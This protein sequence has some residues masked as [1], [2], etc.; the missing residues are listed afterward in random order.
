MRCI[1]DTK[2]ALWA[3]EQNMLHVEAHDMLFVM[4]KLD[5]AQ[6]CCCYCIC[7]KNCDM[8]YVFVF[9]GGKW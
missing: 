2:L 8:L 3:N 7:V 5:F 1:V 4:A 9:R 6:Y